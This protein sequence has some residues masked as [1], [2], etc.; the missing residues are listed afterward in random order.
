MAAVTVAKGTR[1]ARV[2][3]CYRGLRDHQG[4][5]HGSCQLGAGVCSQFSKGV[6]AIIG[7]YDRK[8][9]NMLMSFCGALHVCFVTPSFPIETA[10]QFVIQLRPELQDA[11][12]GVIDH[13]G[14]N[15]FVYMYSSD[16]VSN[17]LIQRSSQHV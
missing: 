7:L 17:K 12:V 4:R 16:S 3:R 1:S 8:T 5:A 9:V 6:Y 14:W 2:D 10:N 15:K 11:L 13:Y